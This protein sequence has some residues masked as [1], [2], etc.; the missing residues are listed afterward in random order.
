MLSSSCTVQLALCA[1]SPGFWKGGEG[2]QKWDQ[3]TADPATSDPI[4]FAVGFATFTV[5]PWLDAWL[6]G[7]TYLDALNLPVHGDV[8]I[9]LAFKYIAARLNQAAFGVPTEVAALLD[10]IDTYFAT[11]PVG[12]DPDGQDKQDGRDLL[13]PLNE[14]FSTVGEEF[15][16]NTGDIPEL[17]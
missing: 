1:L 14:Y 8:T 15:C 7:S 11:N 16:P 3:L 6:A 5:F 13:D 4:A 10:D 2:V 17:E 9:Q 12:S